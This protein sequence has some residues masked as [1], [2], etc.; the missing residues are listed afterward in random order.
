MMQ[1]E[2]IH[3]LLVC[4]RN[5]T[6]HVASVIHL[7]NGTGYVRISGR[8]VDKWDHPSEA[9]AVIRKALAPPLPTKEEAKNAEACLWQVACKSLMWTEKTAIEVNQAHETLV[10]FIEAAAAAGGE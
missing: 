9:M 7:D 1:L 6:R 5:R 4:Y 2:E 3:E 8:N 10:R